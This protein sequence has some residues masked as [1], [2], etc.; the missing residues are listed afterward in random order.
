LGA[1]E[2][3]G[4]GA[5]VGKGHRSSRQAGRRRHDIFDNL[6]IRRRDRLDAEA[7]IT[8]GGQCQDLT[9]S[10]DVGNLVGPVVGVRSR[11]C[12]RLARLESVRQPAP[13]ER[14]IVSGSSG[15]STKKTVEPDNVGRLSATSGR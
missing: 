2:R 10:G 5:V 3:I 8:R 6:N 13:C 4:V 15:R 7:E 1:R 9:V 11:Y 12:D 14:S